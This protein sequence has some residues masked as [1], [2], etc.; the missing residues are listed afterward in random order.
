MTA[1]ERH[2]RRWTQLE[3]ERLPSC[4]PA[5]ACSVRRVERLQVNYLAGYW[6][7]LLVEA[8]RMARNWRKRKNTKERKRKIGL[9]LNWD[10]YWNLIILLFFIFTW[11]CA[12]FSHRETCNE[13][14]EG[15]STSAFSVVSMFAAFFQSSC[16]LHLPLSLLKSSV[17]FAHVQITKWVPLKESSQNL[18][19][20]QLNDQLL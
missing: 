10:W 14:N 17:I 1:L 3:A 18:E 19:K 12:N 7:A 11:Y 15:L 5:V 20:W 6:S 9:R 8:P 4:L 2:E 13:R 16:A